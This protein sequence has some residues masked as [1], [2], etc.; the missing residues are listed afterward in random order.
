MSGP[1][2]TGIRP[3]SDQYQTDE[4]ISVLP[5][6]S[7]K[8]TCSVTGLPVN[9]ESQD[10]LCLKA[11]HL[12]KKDFPEL[13]PVRMHLHKAIPM[14]AGLGGGSSDGAFTLALLNKKFNLGISKE[15]LAV[16]ALQL[17][18]DCP[19]FLHNKPCYATGRGEA[20]EDIA[21]DLSHYSFLLVNPGIHINTGWAFSNIIPRDAKS[22]RL[23]E[24]IQEPISDWKHH[25]VNDFEKP[26][27]DLY[28]EIRSIRDTLYENGALYASMSGSGSTVFGIFPYLAQNLEALQLQLPYRSFLIRTSTF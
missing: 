7:D 9:G 14:G 6:F 12:L 4:S 19:F 5:S 21:L 8:I 28:P 22:S 11:Y 26:V 18:S 10:N 13:P 24:A 23:K 20:L 25:L 3:V 1:T 17:G 16:Y 2:R 15:Q 27:F